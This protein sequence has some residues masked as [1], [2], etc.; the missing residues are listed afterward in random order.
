MNLFLRIVCVLLAAFFYFCASIGLLLLV[1]ALFNPEAM[2]EGFEFF[3]HG[4]ALG[5][6]AIVFTAVALV[7]VPLTV[8]GL[9]T[10]GF[11]ALLVRSGET[12]LASESAGDI[13]GTDSISQP[14]DDDSGL[15]PPE[16]ENCV[17][18][19]AKDRVLSNEMQSYL[20][21]LKRYGIK[22]NVEFHGSAIKRV[23]IHNIESWDKNISIRFLLHRSGKLLWSDGCGPNEYYKYSPFE[24]KYFDFSDLEGFDPVP[25]ASEIIVDNFWTGNPYEPSW[26][27][28][29]AQL[30]N[31]IFM[32]EEYERKRVFVSTKEKVER[33][34]GSGCLGAAVWLSAVGIG[35]FAGGSFFA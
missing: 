28:R 9:L 19:Q 14:S 3:E 17:D 31:L 25:D 23:F 34:T 21:R 6:F 30:R 13:V 29:S 5:L 8:G 35:I 7:G 2:G 33:K 20:E 16:V 11:R 26:I 4:I 27:A 32:D 24:E 1:I 15:E 10:W 12:H 22:I 18:D